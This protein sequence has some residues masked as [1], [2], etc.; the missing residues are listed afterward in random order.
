MKTINIVLLS[1]LKITILL[2][3]LPPHHLDYNLNS[4]LAHLV[5]SSQLHKNTWVSIKNKLQIKLL[6]LQGDMNGVC[7]FRINMQLN[8]YATL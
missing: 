4:Y 5:F 6:D 8:P 3:P 7:Q 2:F 1:S